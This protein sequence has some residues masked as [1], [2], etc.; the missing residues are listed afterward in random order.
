MEYK[1]ILELA[2]YCLEIGVETRYCMWFGGY[3]LYFNNGSGCTQHSGSYG[4]EEG[5]VEFGYTGTDLDFTRTTLEEAKKFVKENKEFLN[6][7][8]N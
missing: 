4:A 3:V 2:E 8:D 5:C 1:E 6:R 7:A